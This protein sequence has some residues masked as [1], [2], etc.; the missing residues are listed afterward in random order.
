MGSIFDRELFLFLRQLR[1][2]N[3]RPWFLKNKARYEEFVKAPLLKF[4]VE[5]GPGLLKI[6]KRLKVDAR[7]VGGS[8]L[9]IYRDVRFSKDKSPFKTNGALHF[10]YRLTNADIHA[11]GY[12]LHLE[13]GA[14]FAGAGIWR[15]DP[16]TLALIR[17]AIAKNPVKWKKAR[18][19]G[20]KTEG[21]SLTRPPR[22]FDPAHPCIE[23][24]KLKD[25]VVMIPFTDA[26]V[27]SDDFSKKFVAACKRAEPLMEFL[28]A[29]LGL[30]WR[31]G[32]LPKISKS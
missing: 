5:A 21:E 26:E 15:P 32:G 31:Q 9:R 28:A 20:L 1:A 6:C 23:D 14:N 22:G 4:V 13:P 18:V 17:Y 25:F 8:M 27:C 12:Y 11:P 19:K 30:P 3:N 7:P 24:I 29:S 2:N 16:A 10:P